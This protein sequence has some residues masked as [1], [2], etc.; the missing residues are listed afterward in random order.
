MIAEPIKNRAVIL[1]GAPIADAIKN[2]VAEEVKKLKEDFG[3]IT[4]LVVVR[5]VNDQPSEVYVCKKVK[6]SQEL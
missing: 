3:I 4:C 1:S 5:V 6:T 2:E